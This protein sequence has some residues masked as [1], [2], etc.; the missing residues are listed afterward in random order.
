MEW[1]YFVTDRADKCMYRLSNT[2][3]DPSV[4]IEVV[5]SALEPSTS[6]KTTGIYML[7]GLRRDLMYQST[8]T[9]VSRAVTQWTCL[10]LLEKERH[11]TVAEKN[12]ISL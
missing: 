1:E 6:H 5:A 12:R 7:N 3:D 4:R 8:S 10:L 9:S 11:A 2:A